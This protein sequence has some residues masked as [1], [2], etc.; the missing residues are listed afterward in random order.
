MPVICFEKPVS[1]FVGLGFP[2][3]VE[4]IWDAFVVLNEWPTRGPAHEAVLNACR[5][6]MNGKFD[7]ETIRDAF[8]AFAR[9]AGILMPDALERSA[10]ISTSSVSRGLAVGPQ[11]R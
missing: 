2:R 1:I 4:S 10:H 9:E 6:G 11:W 7:V 3:E 5:A 8:E